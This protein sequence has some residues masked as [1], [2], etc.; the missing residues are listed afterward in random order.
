METKSFAVELKAL[1]DAGIFE[2][3]LAVYNNVDEQGDVIEPGAFTKTLQENGGSVPLLWSHDV[4]EPLGTLEL[5]D[6]PSALLAR[7]KLVLAVPGAAKAYALMK[8]GAVRGL[9][10]GFRTIKAIDSAGVRRLKELKLY[11]GSLTAI[12][13][14]REALVTAVKHQSAGDMEA[15]ECFRNAH[16][17]LKDFHRRLIEGD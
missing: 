14:N 7:G 3:K 12:P 6:S 15:L 8:A 17:D 10:I 13:A 2:G 4:S 11:E 16:R 9:S 5:T 1:D